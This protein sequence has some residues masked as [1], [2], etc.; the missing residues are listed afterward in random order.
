MVVE[1]GKV[2]EFAHPFELLVMNVKRS[3]SIDRESTF[4]MMVLQTGL[5]NSQSIFEIARRSYIRN[6]LKW[7]YMKASE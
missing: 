6:V 5:K 3:A 7:E 1:D 2:G 4:A